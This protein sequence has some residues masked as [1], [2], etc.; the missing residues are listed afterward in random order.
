MLS[1]GSVLYG[2]ENLASGFIESGSL[3]GFCIV[4]VTSVAY[5][6]A[7]QHSGI[8]LYNNSVRFALMQS[9]NSYIGF[10]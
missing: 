10:Y 1:K 6:I 9:G 2:I 7:S 3:L 8:R 4:L 5:K